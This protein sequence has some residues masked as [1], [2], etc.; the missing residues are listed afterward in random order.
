MAKVKPSSM[1]R[2]DRE[3]SLAGFLDIVTNLKTKDESVDFLFGILTPSEA[4][5]LSRRMQI[6]EMLL[7]DSYTYDG[8]RESLGVG[9]RTIATVEH[10]L[11]TGNDVRDVWLASLIRGRSK[12]KKSSKPI[13]SRKGYSMSLLDRYPQH[14]I[15]SDLISEILR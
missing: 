7:R 9:Y 13:G 10:W 11:H 15:L 2:S 6:A 12:K 8:I 1:S 14:R 3:I 4:L 5:M